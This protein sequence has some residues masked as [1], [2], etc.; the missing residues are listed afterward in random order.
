V[1]ATTKITARRGSGRPPPAAAGRA[2]SRRP[3]GRSG[4]CLR[5]AREIAE[6]LYITLRTVE[7]HLTHVFRKLQITTRAQLADSMTKAGT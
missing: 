5:A 7:T 2:T 4:R 1:A 3:A 6:Q